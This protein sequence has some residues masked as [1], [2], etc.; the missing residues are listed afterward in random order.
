MYESN[1]LVPLLRVGWNKHDSNYLSTFMLEYNG[2]VILDIRQPSA[3]ICE[4]M[5]HHGPIN[6]T[7]WAPHSSA[8][9]VSGG[10]DCQALIWDLSTMPN[11]VTEPILAYTAEAEINQLQWAA[12][13]PEWVAISFNKTLQI[14]RV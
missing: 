2:V 9:I 7:A 8:H 14:L 12:S 3:P 11:P 10:D 5:G 13:Q 1:E 4:L 6:S